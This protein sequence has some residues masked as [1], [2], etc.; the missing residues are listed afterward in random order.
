[1]E[2]KFY[3]APAIELEQIA[4]EKGFAGSGNIDKPTQGSG[5]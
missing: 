3:V 2:K 4:V 5:W 1:M